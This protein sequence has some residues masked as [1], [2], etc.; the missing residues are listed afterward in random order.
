MHAPQVNRR[1]PVFGLG[2]ND[3]ESARAKQRDCVVD[4]VVAHRGRREGGELNAAM[5]SPS[6]RMRELRRLLRQPL[7]NRIIVFIDLVCL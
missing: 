6:K 1:D 2:V 4:V 3:R 7:R 5:L